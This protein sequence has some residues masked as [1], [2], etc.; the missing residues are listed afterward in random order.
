LPQTG[1]VIGR[2][3]GTDPGAGQA[4][5]AEQLLPTQQFGELQAGGGAGLLQVVPSQ[6]NPPLTPHTAVPQALPVSGEQL[7]FPA[8]QLPL[9]QQCA[10][11]QLALLSTQE[12]PERVWHPLHVGS[13]GGRGLL[14]VDPSQASP[15]CPH[16]LGR[17]E[18]PIFGEQLQF[19]ATQLPALQHW[20][21]PQP[22]FEVPGPQSLLHWSKTCVPQFTEP[23]F[24]L[25]QLAG[26]VGLGNA[27]AETLQVP[28]HLYVPL[29]QLPGPVQPLQAVQVCPYF[30][31][32]NGGG[33]GADVN[34]VAFP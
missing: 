1:S 24:A 12:Q 27:G 13:T 6:A 17:Q 33:G 32:Q 2:P 15:P 29:L 14:Q 19:P 20:A 7:Q 30:G 8:T 5:G 3:H 22:V 9:L 18:L 26:P 28:S 34:R 23:R 11:P 25:P 21:V 10:V 4:P 31:S 16:A